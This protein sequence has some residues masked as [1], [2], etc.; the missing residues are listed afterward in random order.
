MVV[1]GQGGRHTLERIA[2]RYA[3]SP[4]LLERMNGPASR[5]RP[6]K[7][8]YV[9]SRAIAPALAPDGLVLN[10]PALRIFWFKAGHV[11]GSWPVTL[12]RPF[13]PTEDNVKRWRTPTGVFKIVAKAWHPEW[14]V[15][16]DIRPD[17]KRPRPIVPYGD[18]EN[19]L[20]V[21]KLQLDFPTLYVHGSKSIAGIGYSASH[22]CIRVW[23]SVAARFY[24]DL[25]I[26]TPVVMTYQPVQVA[27]EGGRVYLEVDPDVYKLVPDRLGLARRLLAGAGLAE[28][29]DPVRVERTVR[30]SLGI[31]IDVTNGMTMP[32]TGPATSPASP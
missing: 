31:P 12:G 10:I 8:V 18:K 2:E 11:E 32:P 20:G 17:L 21:A 23:N 5:W 4:R 30:A 19:P 1:T 27:Q 29:A 22:G 13:D 24:R 28:R 15:P 16:L 7:R 3:A 25:P 6:G 14:R 9:S 26:G